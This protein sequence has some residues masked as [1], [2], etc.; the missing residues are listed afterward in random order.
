MDERKV[1]TKLVYKTRSKSPAYWGFE[2]NGPVFNRVSPINDPHAH[3]LY[4]HFKLFLDY[5]ILGDTNK[6]R[7]EKEMPEVCTYIT[8]ASSDFARTTRTEN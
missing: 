8:R 6:G 5:D 3:R 1:P 4:K 2:C 7:V